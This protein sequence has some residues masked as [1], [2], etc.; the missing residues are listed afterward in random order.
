[1]EWK[2]LQPN[3]E[4]REKKTAFRGGM[5][6]HEL[7]RKEMAKEAAR[8]QGRKLQDPRLE[9]LERAA[10]AWHREKEQERL[11]KNREESGRSKASVTC[12][13][14][15]P[16][17]GAR[18]KEA[19]RSEGKQAA[20]DINWPPLKLPR[21]G[22]EGEV[23]KRRLNSASM[24][25]LVRKA[26]ARE[27]R[28]ALGIPRPDPFLVAFEQEAAR[29]RE[30]KEEVR[31]SI[32][33]EIGMLRKLVQLMANDGFFDDGKRGEEWG[34]GQVSCFVD[35]VPQDGWNVI[36]VALE[37]S[38]FMLRWEW[39][40]LLGIYQAELDDQLSLKDYVRIAPDEIEEY[41]RKNK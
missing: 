36:I 26:V 34:I 33:R 20:G 15:A 32:R 25:V 3:K 7:A 40:D 17:T 30:S 41:L 10:T 24:G 23:K 29:W 18:V 39:G 28:I 9:A 8:A 4:E 19:K 21:P 2:T 37:R 14:I 35:K 22:G 13:D 1:M 12:I 5:A 16:V 31:R 11:R 38:Q 27:K 6:A